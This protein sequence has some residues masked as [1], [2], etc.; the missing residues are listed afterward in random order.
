MAAVERLESVQVRIVLRGVDCPSCAAKIERAVG[1][2]A[3][4]E[5]AALDFATGVLHVRALPENSDQLVARVRDVVSQLEP[6]V[7]VS[8]E[9]AKGTTS[10]R[11]SSVDGYKEP[12]PEWVRLGVGMAMYAGAMLWPGSASLAL[13]IASY[14]ILGG[15]TLRRAMRNM[16]RGQ[17]FDE[18]FLMS[19]A[20][21]G[22]F[23]LGEYP[24]AVAVALFYEIGE[25]LQT[26][27]VGQSRRSI[28]ELVDVR[29]EQANLL[30]ASGAINV[31]SPDDIRPGQHIL[32]KPGERVP[33]D[34][35]VLDG[36]SLVD[37]AALTGE[38]M[39][40]EVLRGDEVLAG[41]VNQTGALT[42]R[43]TRPYAESTIARILRLMED[44]SARRAPTERFI[45]RFAR[46][47]TPL[48]V[49]LA[50]ALALVP[51]LLFGRSW[52]T[53]VYS[54]LVF[55]VASCPCALLV[56]VPLGF[57]GGIG[58]AARRGI[59]VKGAN[60]LEGL[61]RAHTVVFDK[62]G[63]LTRG[64]LKVTEVKPEDG[65]SS[66]EL[67]TLAAAAES[68]SLHPAAQCV[69]QAAGSGRESVD[70]SDF[71]E[72]AGEGVIC[73]LD[74]N[75]VGVG[76][77]R[78]MSRLGVAVPDQDNIGGTL[79]HVAVDGI[80]QGYVAVSD[81]LKPDAHE[82]VQGL[83]RSGVQRIAMLTG[84]R[85]A[86]ADTVGK[87]LGLDEVQSNLLPDQKVKE[88]ER[89]AASTSGTLVFVGDGL[90]DAPVLARAD[91]GVAM[92]GTGS[93]VAIEAADVVLMTDEPSRLVEAI[94]I[95]RRTRAIVWQNVCLAL[96]VKGVVLAMGSTA[97]ATL[98][99]AVFADVGVALLAVLNSMRAI[100]G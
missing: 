62:T 16:M 66:E 59:L 5:N 65:I 10:H 45:T 18:N 89:L 42:V 17:V 70:I 84:D 24:E 55:L 88:L 92:G 95:A 31:V 91:V 38:P 79:V 67:L 34:G 60:F 29:P 46:Y 44:A 49:L 74:G 2:L 90:N 100:R 54:S 58:G 3:G 23:A 11:R 43:V 97:T 85:P 78:L 86:V 94:R 64:I 81:E 68:Y 96:T 22:A 99:A 41:F 71:T 48:V 12:G 30:E 6:D 32:I 13:F 20:T 8:Q 33:L 19:I 25:T 83:R 51:P 76:S 40:R 26:L 72:V 52:N 75:L 7:V 47:Y 21:L 73:R 98:W 61:T 57:F 37:T 77:D 28:M 15:P 4:V 36:H 82:T 80:Y 87:L 93:D 39:P 27:A 9:D 1:H 14:V 35:D 63:T 53:W 50:A 69:R 56:S